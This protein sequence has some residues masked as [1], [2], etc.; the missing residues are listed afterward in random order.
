[1]VKTAPRAGNGTP[2]LPELEKRVFQLGKTTVTELV[3]RT[4]RRGLVRRDLDRTRPRG[5]TV[6]L[7]PAGERRLANPFGCSG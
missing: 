6:R 7:T 2:G 4:E 3:L 1:M 5:I